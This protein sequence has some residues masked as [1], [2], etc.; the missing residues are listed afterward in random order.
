MVQ[1]SDDRLAALFAQCASYEGPI[2]AVVYVAL[3]QLE[4]GQEL[5]AHNYARVK[6]VEEMIADLHST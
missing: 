6:H 3:V 5:S 2:S 4:A 1:L